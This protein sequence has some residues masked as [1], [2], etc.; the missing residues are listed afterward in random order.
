[1]VTRDEEVAKLRDELEA[2]RAART[3]ALEELDRRTREVR[4]LEERNTTLERELGDAVRAWENDRAVIVN[5]R[6]AAQRYAL[7]VERERDELLETVNTLKQIG[8]EL[9]ET[10][11]NQSRALDELSPSVPPPAQWTERDDSDDD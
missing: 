11:R 1:M 2:V 7:A 9:V 3:F 6:T 4:V 10:V 5:E 8:E